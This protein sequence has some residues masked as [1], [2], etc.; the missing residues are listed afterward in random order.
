MLLVFACLLKF[1]LWFPLNIVSVL[2]KKPPTQSWRKDEI[3]A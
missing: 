1:G 3:I 2:L